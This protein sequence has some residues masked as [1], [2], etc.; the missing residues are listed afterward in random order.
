MNIAFGSMVSAKGGLPGMANGGGF[1][2][3]INFEI[4]YCGAST[5]CFILARSRALPVL[6]HI[7]VGFGQIQWV[8][9]HLRLH[10]PRQKGIFPTPEK[11]TIHLK[12]IVLYKNGHCLKFASLINNPPLHLY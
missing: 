6:L 4:Y 12:V 1:M 5:D 9:S 11:S 10:P 2:S 3:S 7:F 8:S